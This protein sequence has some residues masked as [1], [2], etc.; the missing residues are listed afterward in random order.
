MRGNKPKPMEKTPGAAPASPRHPL[1]DESGA[2]LVVVLLLLMVMIAL[3]PVAVHNAS[4]DI[5]RTKN[6]TEDRT[7]FYLAEAGVEHAKS[8]LRTLEFNDLLDGADNLPGTSSSDSA[9]DDNG[10]LPGASNVVTPWSDA[11]GTYSYTEVDGHPS[12]FN[13]KYL[14]RVVDNND[15]PVDPLLPTEYKNTWVDTDNVIL[16]D[17][18]GISDQGT[19]K[20][21]QSKIYSI[22]LPID[23]NGFPAAVTMVD[24][25]VRLTPDGTAF[26][27]NGNG[28]TPDSNPPFFQ[29]DT[30][31][32]TK[33]A[34]A[35]P[36]TGTGFDKT[37]VTSAEEDRF[38]GLGGTKSINEGDT[39]LSL[40][41]LQEL[42]DRVL[43]FPGV[44][45]VQN[46]LST[47]TLGDAANP[48]IF[49]VPDS[50]TG[51]GSLVGHGIL[52]VD[53][54][55]T[56]RGNFEWHGLI[57][58]GACSTCDGLIHA[59]G[60]TK[61]YGA[62]VAANPTSSHS[63]ET[64]FEINDN[65]MFHYSCSVLTAVQNGILKDSFKMVSWR[66]VPFNS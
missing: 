57:I 50:F 34:V 13:G 51:E 48:G 5:N 49:H 8:L 38:Y 7:A 55:F 62:V 19:T 23:L 11:N 32:P 64:R 4:T 22:K 60:D 44:V 39:T 66:E 61:V 63:N 29:L 15:P 41:D 20:R 10:L 25:D 36:A 9:I 33:Y 43:S 35:A 12:G 2:I 27:V 30:T 26:L 21:I 18:V 17:A 47:G 52:V 42:R 56:V 45:P 31:C 14:I 40:A 37:G 1:E 53:R 46:N 28:V 16:V 59:E 58:V 6:Y 24:G 54:T 65:S 3:I